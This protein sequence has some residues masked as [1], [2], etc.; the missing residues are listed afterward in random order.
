MDKQG[1]QESLNVVE[2][3]THTSKMYNPVFTG[4]EV[5]FGSVDEGN[6]EVEQQIDDQRSGVFCQKHLDPADLS[7]QVSEVEGRRGSHREMLQ[8]VL[9]LQGLPLGVETN[10]LSG[11]VPLG[12]ALVEHILYLPDGG[13]GLDLVQEAELVLGLGVQYLHLKENNSLFS[14]FGRFAL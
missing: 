9:I 6:P 14:F 3:V 1:L 7:S 8:D 5:I 2:G 12:V 4:G 13:I 11:R 10:R